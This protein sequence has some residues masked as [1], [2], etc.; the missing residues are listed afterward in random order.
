MNT[1]TFLRCSTAHSVYRDRQITPPTTESDIHLFTT[2]CTLNETLLA[3]QKRVE[4]LMEEHRQQ[5]HKLETLKE[6]FSKA[7]DINRELKNEKERMPGGW[8]RE[9]DYGK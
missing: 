6:K 2:F 8:L 5:V 7:E 1:N 9:K 3:A 4:E